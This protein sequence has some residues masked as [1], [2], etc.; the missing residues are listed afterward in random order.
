MTDIV[1]RLAE[2][3]AWALRVFLSEALENLWLAE[4][5]PLRLN[6]E[7]WSSELRMLSDQRAQY[8]ALFQPALVGLA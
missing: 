2:E 4:D 6:L 5:E 7:R 1:W 8:D 3:D